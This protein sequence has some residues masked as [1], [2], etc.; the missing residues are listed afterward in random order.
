[1][2]INVRKLRVPIEYVNGR[3][4]TVEQDTQEHIDQCVLGVIS[5]LLGSRIEKPEF[6]I[7]DT[8]FGH[9]V[10]T[11]QAVL[12]VI[13]RWETRADVSVDALPELLAARA[14][15]FVVTSRGVSDVG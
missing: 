14:D 7:P 9:G 1:M 8:R 3:V 10:G 11:A 15:A 12:G 13:E 2:T 6:G 4:L 5:T